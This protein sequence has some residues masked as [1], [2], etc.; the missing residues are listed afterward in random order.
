MH[1][2]NHQGLYR[3]K[4]LILYFLS[5]LLLSVLGCQEDA[6]KIKK[7]NVILIVID[8]WRY[9]TLSLEINGMRVMPSANDFAKQNILFTNAFSQSPWTLPS[10]GTLFTSL[11]PS[12]HGAVRTG[13]LRGGKNFGILRDD[14]ETLAGILKKNGFKTYAVAC[15]NNLSPEFHINRGFDVYQIFRPEMKA[16]RLRADEAFQLGLSWIK[17]NGQKGNF[18]AMIHLFDP[19]LSY[20][21]P[22]EFSGMFDPSYTGRYKDNFDEKPESVRENKILLN[23][24]EK[25]HIRNLYN[26]EVAFCDREFGKFL[27]ALNDLNLLQDSVLILT[28]DHGEELWDHQSFEHGHT[29]YDELVHVPLVM[30]FPVERGIQGKE[31]KGCVGLIDLM[32]T[33][34]D[35]MGIPIPKNV[36][37]RS[38][39]P[40]IMSDD[41][42]KEEPLY[43]GSLLYGTEK[44]SIRQGNY[45]YIRSVVEGGKDELYDLRQ[46]PAEAKNIIDTEYPRKNIL[47]LKLMAWYESNQKK[48][49]NQKAVNLDKDTQERLKSLGYIQ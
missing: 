1:S 35:F 2:W 23:A 38:I 33:I 36:Q 22:Q 37:G 14:T 27:R 32:P 49:V 16:M 34:L 19:H 21:P 44:I 18:F 24:Q 8:T 7:H 30:H 29:V 17:K 48:A 11:Y 10:F 42:F 3:N 45:K 46:D 6:G 15:N 41:K 39:L 31:I 47:K 25:E 26:A 9:D 4:R 20:N 12:V 43:C 13:M 5:I 40:Y 28:A